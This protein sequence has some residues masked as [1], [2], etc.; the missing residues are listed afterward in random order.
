MIDDDEVFANMNLCV[1]LYADDTII[2]SENPVDLQKALDAMKEYC[3]DNK[4]YVNVAKR[5]CNILEGESLEHTN[6]YV[7]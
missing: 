2:L 5:S 4:L 7:S 1:L 3:G 6:I